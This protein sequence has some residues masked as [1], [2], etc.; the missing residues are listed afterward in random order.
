MGWTDLAQDMHHGIRKMSVSSLVAVKLVRF[1]KRPQL[2]AY[3]SKQI[4]CFPKHH[5]QVC[6][7]SVHA[8]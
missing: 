6:F 3:V 8:V 7:S 5:E 2:H 4:N 1:S